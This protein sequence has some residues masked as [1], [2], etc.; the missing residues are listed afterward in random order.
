LCQSS[1][2]KK[3]CLRNGDS[4]N[5]RRNASYILPTIKWND[6]IINDDGIAV[7]DDGVTNYDRIAV[8]DDGVT[9]D[10]RSFSNGAFSYAN[11]EQ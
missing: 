1:S 11:V 5:R 8:N 7:N 4:Y 2:S 9:N 6:G 10:D 3:K